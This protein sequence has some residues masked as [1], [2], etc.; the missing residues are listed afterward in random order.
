MKKQLLFYLLLGSLAA[1]TQENDVQPSPN[2]LAGEVSGAYRT[3]PYVDPSC[4]AIPASQMPVVTLRPESD[5]IVSLVYAYQFPKPGSQQLTG[6][7]L[8]RRAD[9]AVQLTH[10]N[11]VL[12][13]VQIDRVFTNNGMEKQGRLLRINALDT[14]PN[15]PYFTGVKE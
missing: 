1:C 7:Q 2:T 3:N 5:G 10:G 13:T 15:V 8:S 9:N 12:G 11:V 6:I 4:V 14:Q